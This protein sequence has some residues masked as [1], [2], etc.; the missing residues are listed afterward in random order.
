[1]KKRITGPEAGVSVIEVLIVL[2]IVVILV[3]IAVAQFGTSGQNLERQNI[4]REFKISLERARYDSVKRR[5]SECADQS[6]VV[7]ESETRFSLVTDM[8]QNGTLEPESETRVIDFL[9]RGPVQLLAPDITFP[10]VIRFDHRGNSSTGDCGS[11]T[12]VEVGFIFCNGPCT[13]ATAGPENSSIVFVSPTGTTAMLAGGETLPNFAPPDVTVISGD[14]EVNPNLAVWYPET[15][16]SPSPSPSPSGSPLPLPT[17]DPSPLPTIDP[18]PLPSITPTPTPT[19][20]PVACTYGQ[21]PTAN[22]C[23][24]MSPMWVR[25]NGKC[26]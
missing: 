7:I 19:P 11:E 25:N 13:L 8:N 20:T 17:V 18:S 9:N 26:Q 6:R 2:V 3:T 5:A 1:M 21:R 23:V 24:C 15:F 14:L 16:S 10:T 22:N 12:G 4:S